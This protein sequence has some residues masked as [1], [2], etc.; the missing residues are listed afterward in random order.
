LI[1]DID[2]YPL[3]KEYYIE[4]LEKIPEGSYGHIN[5][6]GYKAGNWYDNPK[7]G[8][9]GYYHCAKGSKFKE[10]LSL[11]NSFE[12][13][14]K[15]I[16]ESRRYGA[17]LNG[18]YSNRENIPER[19]RKA[20]PNSYEYIC[21]E[22]HLS[23]ERLISKRNEIHSFT[24]PSDSIRLESPIFYNEADHNSYIDIHCPRPYT[25]YGKSLE[26]VLHK[27]GDN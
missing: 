9:P 17:A 20:I 10:F 5:A 11:S 26:E 21:C 6:N 23:T 15:Y 1:G 22:E 25:K 7:L 24:Y 4:S 16:Y 8:L 2:L 12:S 3:K 18:L 13:D 19:V 27:Y 14:I